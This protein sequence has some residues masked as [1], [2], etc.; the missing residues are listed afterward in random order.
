MSAETFDV[1]YA[2]ATVV[3]Q[4]G[5]GIRDIGIRDGLIAAVGEI[6]GASAGETIDCAGLHILP[7]V[8]DTQVHFREP[9][10]EHKEDLESG[11]LAAVMGGVTA[12]FEMPNTNPLTTSAETLADK[13]ASRAPT[14]CIAT[15]PSGSAA[16]TSNTHE[17]ARNSSACR[18]LR[19]SRCSS[20]PPPASAPGRGRCKGRRRRSSK[21]HP[22]SSAAFHAEDEPMLRER[23]RPA[24]AD[25]DPSSHPVWRSPETAALKRD[26]SAS[27]GSRSETGCPHPHPAHLH[28]GG[29]GVSSADL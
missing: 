3:N 23:K 12:V 4:D 26:A 9:G 27:C 5:A 13:V 6:D 22:A 24:G 17:V 10:A 28:G 21:P 20:A 16:P 15:S 2:G 1:I 11:S 14:A 7:G 19:G 8:I 29:D 25:N 18:V